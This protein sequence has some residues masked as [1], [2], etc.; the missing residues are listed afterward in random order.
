M[1]DVQ[2]AADWFNRWGD[3]AERLWRAAGLIGIQPFIIAAVIAIV[4]GASIWAARATPIIQATTPFSYVVAGLLVAILTV[5]FL[6][7]LLARRPNR[8]KSPRVAYWVGLHHAPYYLARPSLLSAFQAISDEHEKAAEEY[9]A[10]QAITLKRMMPA[11]KDEI[12]QDSENRAKLSMARS[13][14]FQLEAQL[15]RQ[16]E[17]LVQDVISQL[18]SGELVAVGFRGT[19]TDHDQ[20]AKPIPAS[21]WIVLKISPTDSH[22]IVRGDGVAYSGVQ[23][24]RTIT[25]W[26]SFWNTLQ[27]N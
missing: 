14:K 16:L 5:G 22:N 15:K 21:Q 23:V 19:L 25:W 2:K 3:V 11:Y 8:A 24:G 18:V 17:L 4:S 27:R 7:T 1:A 26:D 13:P 12:S 9:G 10:A 20:E 6:R